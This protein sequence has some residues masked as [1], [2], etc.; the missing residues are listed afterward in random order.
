MTVTDYKKEIIKEVSNI[1]PSIRAKK[2]FQFSPPS[3][4]AFNTAP[5]FQKKFNVFNDAG[6]NDE[7]RLNQNVNAN[8]NSAV[9]TNSQLYDN[10]VPIPVKTSSN[11]VH[12]S[13]VNPM[14][15]LSEKFV[16]ASSLFQ[17]QLSVPSSSSTVPLLSF[18]QN[19]STS[20]LKYA[21]RRQRRGIFI[22]RNLI[23]SKLALKQKI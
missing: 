18:P 11:Y 19:T 12:Q 1:T 13:M 7:S 2:T 20:A 6:F 8:V 17:Q 9:L 16:S 22:Q 21:C 3:K 15:I 10:S 5:T 4:L 14:P 23:F